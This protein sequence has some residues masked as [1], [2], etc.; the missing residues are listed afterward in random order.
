[1]CYL[2]KPEK[3]CQYNIQK[4][5]HFE[6]DTGLI[7]MMSKAEK[8]ITMI[9]AIGGGAAGIWGAYT[10]H[11]SSKFKQPFDEREQMVNSFTSQITS[12]EKRNA[13]EEVIRIRLDL[14]KYEENW[15][16]IRQLTN[17]VKPIENLSATNLSENQTNA[18]R[19]L[20]NELSAES[21]FSSS[22]PPKT[23]GAAYLAAGNY[24]QAINQFNSAG[25]NSSE[26]NLNAL[27]AVAYGRLA[28]VTDNPE[29]RATYEKSAMNHFIFARN[30]DSE[31]RRKVSDFLASAPELEILLEKVEQR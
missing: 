26:S 16:T 18:V 25:L 21:S 29:L 28:I 8:I 11:D 9:V 5:A 7:S 15:R 1:M 19:K 22:V 2:V 12:A 27:Q 14:E 24:G 6:S 4:L 31:Q 10:A 23:L 30:V 3:A 20:L 17:L 13:N